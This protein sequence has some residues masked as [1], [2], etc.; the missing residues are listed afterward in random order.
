MAKIGR[1]GG[2]QKGSR[3]KATLVAEEAAR[4]ALMNPGTLPLDYMLAIMRDAAQPVN[5]RIAA[6][7]AAAPYCHPRLSPV[8]PPEEPP[9]IDLTPEELEAKLVDILERSGAIK[10]HAAE[11]HLI[12][13]PMGSDKQDKD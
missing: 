12:R 11:P 1:M 7:K 10:E 8:S 4:V 6:A 3:N 2:R 13:L 9:M 5:R